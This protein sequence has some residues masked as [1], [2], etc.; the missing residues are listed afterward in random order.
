MISDREERKCRIYRMIR[1][2]W[3]EEGGGGLKISGREIPVGVDMDM[4]G[5]MGQGGA[6]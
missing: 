4:R 2:E 6:L 3:E 5:R 1:L